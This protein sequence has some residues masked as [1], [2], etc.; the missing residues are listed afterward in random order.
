ML[1]RVKVILTI[2]CLLGP[3]VGVAPAVNYN[4]LDLG[5]ATS[6]L[7]PSGVDEYNGSPLIT[8]TDPA[9]NSG[10]YWTASS[11]LVNI[12]PLLPAS[13][14]ATGCSTTGV[15]SSGQIVGIYTNTGG[16]TPAFL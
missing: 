6:N 8:L 5:G 11:G 1:T 3:I 13:W 4:I 15:N 12:L 14:D 7:M 2:L 16:Y 9:G 10:Y